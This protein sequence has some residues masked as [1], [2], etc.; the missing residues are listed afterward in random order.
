MNREIAMEWIQR[1]L[2]GDLT[3]EESAMLEAYLQTDSELQL[4]RE[5]LRRVSAELDNLPP[6]TP[7]FSLV[8]SILPQLKPMTAVGTPD[9]RRTSSTETMAPSLHLPRL[10]R[11]DTERKEAATVL[12]QRKRLPVWLAKSAMGTAAAC[13]LFGLVTAYGAF[14]PKENKEN[15]SNAAIPA[16]VLPDEGLP[17]P[18]DQQT[19]PKPAA[20]D[21]E[22]VPNKQEK[23]PDKGIAEK[24]QKPKQEKPQQQGN[25][26]SSKGGKDANRDAE[27]RGND[28]KNQDEHKKPVKEKEDKEQRGQKEREEDKERNRKEKNNEKE[29]DREDRDEKE[30][31][32]DKSDP[33][34][35]KGP[36]TDHA[37]NKNKDKPQ[38]PEKPEKKEK[39]GKDKNDDD[40]E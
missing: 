20:E 27:G 3:S 7:P 32:S 16:E 5:R 17:Q 34:P 1:Q 30:K 26:A 21:K 8:D 9:D 15:L 22:T 40:N 4:F 35:P 24:E 10:E 23:Q 6:V 28:S 33:E 25:N 11:L 38:K 12:P 29:N 19:Q 13:L 39:P 36:D 14:G 18:S 2:D 31:R 37:K